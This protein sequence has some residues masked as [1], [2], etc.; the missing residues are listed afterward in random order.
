M[1]ISLIWFFVFANASEAICNFAYLRDS[2]A[3]AFTRF[4]IIDCHEATPLAMT[5]MVKP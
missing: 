2:I 3:N 1:A 5:Q 4:Y